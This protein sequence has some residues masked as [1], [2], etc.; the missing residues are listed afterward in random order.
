[1]VIVLVILSILAM[2]GM[3]F[4]NPDADVPVL[5]TS[6]N[7]FVWFLELGTAL[8]VIY[9]GLFAV[10]STGLT[11]LGTLYTSK[12]ALTL[13]VAI[14]IAGIVFSSV[15]MF[16]ID[17][18]FTAA[19]PMPGQDSETIS[20]ALSSKSTVYPTPAVFKPAADK[21]LISVIGWFAAFIAAQLGISLKAP[22]GALKGK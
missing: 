11:Y 17:R 19:I 2:R 9:G 1:M 20:A 14:A 18:G 21:L 16:Q 7:I 8:A 5:R 4:E 12:R 13:L 22:N 3:V 15:V 10:V 6:W